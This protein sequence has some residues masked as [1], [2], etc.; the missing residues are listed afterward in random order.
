VAVQ[1]MVWMKFDASVPAERVQQHLDAL[2]AL[3]EVVPGIRHISAGPNFTDRADGMTH[4]LLVTLESKEA[5]KIY[6]Q[7]PAHL[8]AAGPMKADASKLMAMDYAC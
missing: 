1:H 2:V 8:A 7:H 6:A 4:G 3:G 5:L